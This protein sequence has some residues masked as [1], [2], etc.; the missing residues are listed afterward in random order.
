LLLKHTGVF[1]EVYINFLIIGLTHN[2]IDALFRR[3][4]WKLKASDCP[5][6]PLLMKSFMDAEKQPVIPHLIK[7][8]PD[9][10]AFMEEYFYSAM[11]PWKGV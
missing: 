9:F 1:W 6:L 10:K 7:E 4:S 8:V 2:N 3:W 11:T 5:I